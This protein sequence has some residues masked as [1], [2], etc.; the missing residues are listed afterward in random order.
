M[1]PSQVGQAEAVDLAT[2]GL[3]IGDEDR[4][5]GFL[6]ALCLVMQA[7][8]HSHP[9][10]TCGK[11]DQ[12]DHAQRHSHPPAGILHTREHR[13]EDRHHPEQHHDDPD[14]PPWGPL[15]H[16]PPAATPDHRQPYDGQH[17]RGRFG[18]QEDDHEDCQQTGADQGDPRRGALALR[19]ACRHGCSLPRS[20]YAHSLPAGSCMGDRH[21]LAR[22]PEAGDYCA[23]WSCT[24][25]KRRSF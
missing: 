19:G 5:P 16:H 12:R 25:A 13:R 7:R 4:M 14:D 15:G 21:D 24:T 10:L 8:S 11:C 20:Q 23:T 3:A 9:C 2:P 17:Q 6:E 22:R 1:L 18:E